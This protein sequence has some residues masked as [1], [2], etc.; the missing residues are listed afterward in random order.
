[1]TQPVITGLGILSPIAEGR[2]EFV[3]AWRAGV[4]AEL[5][6]DGPEAGGMRVP[7][8]KPARLFPDQRKTLRRMDRLSKL[9]C[10]AVGLARDDGPDL[11]DP[12]RVGLAIGTD[13]GTLVETWKFITRLRDKGPAL[14][15][16]IDFPNLV[17]NAGA[18]YAGIFLGLRGP[19]HTFC[20][21]ET[22][23]DEAVAWI[24]DGIA[25]GWILAG[26]AG[27]AE[28]LGETRASATRAARGVREEPMA[29]GSTV[30]VLE[31]PSRA[32]GA[33]LARFLGSWAATMRVPR[34]PLRLPDRFGAELIG[35]I[36]RALDETG[37]APADLGALLLSHPAHPGLRAAVGEALGRDVP[38]TDH[39]LRVG[40]HPADGAFRIALAALLLADRSLP[41]H[42]DADGCGGSAALVVSCARGG[43]LRV[44]V[45]G[46]A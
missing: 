5:V 39:H 2:E 38:A 32:P 43:G 13:L 26:L 1:V 18:G 45:V 7:R 36:R 41:V 29:E 37:V 34:S 46:A 10:T 8:F 35:L 44:S 27:G 4:K 17:P 33:P 11:G 6:P 24:A 42:A 19:S 22:C 31:H 25:S 23:G 21:H 3:A 9:I 12:D 16:P 40:T 14:S 15:R 20:Q 28:E 30:L